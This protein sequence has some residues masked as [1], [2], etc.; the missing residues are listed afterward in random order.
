MSDPVTIGLMVAGTALSAKSAY[1]QGQVAKNQANL[2]ASNLQSSAMQ[3]RMAA[4]QEQAVAQ[5]KA[6]TAGKEAALVQSRAQA[7]AASSGG[8][9]LDVSVAKI[10]SDLAGQGSYNKQVAMYEG[11]SRAP[12]LNYGAELDTWGAEAKRKEGRDAAKAGKTKAVASLVTG[13][14]AAGASG[15]GQSLFSKYFGTYDPISTGTYNP[16]SAFK[17]A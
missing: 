16:G 9:S 6:I 14:A 17:L 2:E 8:G 4:I 3:K 1:D 5:R 10:M 11:D 7:V 13:L 12:D 15:A